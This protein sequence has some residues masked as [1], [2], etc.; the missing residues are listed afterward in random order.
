MNT[1][2]L[3]LYTYAPIALALLTGCG[4]DTWKDVDGGAP[5]LTLQ[6]EH[7]RTEAGLDI[8]IAGKVTDA[9]GISGIDLVCHDINLNK[10]IGIIEIYGEPL[11]EYDLDYTF[12]I[13]DKQKGEDFNIEVTVT[14]IGGRKETR[15]MRVTLDADWTPPYF[16][17]N[18]DKEIIVL[19]KEKTLFNLSFGVADNR[20]VDYVDIDLTDVTAGE[21]APVA[22]A[23]F[24]RRVE[25]NGS[26]KFDFAEKIPLA[27]REATLRATV[28]AYDREA[29]EAA[30]SVSFTSLVKVQ[31]LPDLE[32]MW[33]CDVTDENALNTDIFGV[34]ILCDHTGPFHYQVRYYNE[35]AGTE[36][37][38]LGQKGS[39]SPLC[40]APS[41]ENPSELG[42]NPDEVR[43][44]RLNE[45]GKYY[46]FDFDTK[47]RT[48]TYSTYLPSEA[49]DPVMHM[50]YGSDELN[51]WWDWSGGDI[52]WQEF[53]FG[54][55]PDTPKEVMKMT[56]DDKNP[57]IYIYED[58]QLTKGDKLKFVIHNWHHDNWWNF[59]TWRVDDTEDPGKFLYYGNL[60]PDN[61]KYTGN[62]DWFTWKYGDSVD[63]GRWGDEN[64]R[65][66]FVPDNWV[67][68]SSLEQGGK[69]KLIFDAHTE[70]GRLI[71]QK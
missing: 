52:W 18:P 70:R 35:K 37:C 57:H 43:R 56:R 60:H 19:I 2:K 25:G 24:P 21:D 62:A 42:D 50:H 22:V 34:P 1:K 7:L 51:T 71:P 10:H 59:A 16:T 46:L 23:G 26:G 66:T 32:K 39:F 6:S 45:A 12:K 64:Y 31:E 27:N 44:I 48:V 40:F 38:L 9:D 54:P 68:I 36:V 17:R 13:D 11:K 53:Y 49:L 20:V 63:T 55:M 58:W 4:D 14:D 28:T 61:E 33:L 47:N 3:L 67:N 65:K 29:N 15:Q 69:F 30:H 41:K 8:R 5:T